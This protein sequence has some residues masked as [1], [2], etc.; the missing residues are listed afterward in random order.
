M[1]MSLI[2]RFGYKVVHF[3]EKFDRNSALT[4][5]GDRDLEWSWVI[6]KAPNGSRRTLDFGP[7]N[8]TTPIALSF[9]SDEVVCLDLN[10]PEIDYGVKNITHI[11]GD[12]T[13]PPAGLGKFDLIVNCSSIEHVGL[14]GRYGS[15]EVTDG[16]LIGMQNLH[17]L[18]NESAK[19]LLTVP[20]G[21][22]GVYLPNHR[23]YGEVRLPQLLSGFKVENE[24]FFEKT[25]SR[26]FW[27]ETNKETAL[28]TTSSASFYSIGLFVLTKK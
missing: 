21:K 6:A 24:R 27:A 18:M 1:D 2:K 8:S 16:D 5:S 10:K 25:N 23:V 28:A 11:L 19:M 17:E 15:T 3:G 4:L 12:L 13:S 7:G 20:V 26:R 22:D 9:I 14:P